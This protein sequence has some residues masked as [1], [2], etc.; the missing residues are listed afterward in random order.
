MKF[1]KLTLAIA[2]TLGASVSFSA[3]AIELYVDT[4]T[5]QIYAEPGS[6]RV[7]MGNFEKVG[8]KPAQTAAPVAASR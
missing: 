5:K 8:D 7:L 6:G 1:S 4:K 2:T 3:F